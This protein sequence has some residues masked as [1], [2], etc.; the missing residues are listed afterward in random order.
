MLA[1]IKQA[2]GHL[3]EAFELIRQARQWPEQHQI[4]WVF[5]L[6]PAM[7]TQLHLAQGDLAAALSWSLDPDWEKKLLRPLPNSDVFIYAYEYGKITQAQVMLAQGR[8]AADQNLLREVVAQLEQQRQAGQA[9]KLPWL[10]MKAAALQAL[11]YHA[12]G[13]LAS[14][15]SSL[16]RALIL[17]RPEGYVRLFVDEGA[18][19]AQLLY[20][21][22]R[23]GLRPDYASQLLAAF[24]I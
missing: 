16:E 23:A 19:M 15:L 24:P 22:V 4:T 9:A 14:A 10:Q 20:Q 2:Q 7:E 18:P 3:D 12:L 6:L 5:T 1:R 13:D 21:A 17:A 8:A 11:A